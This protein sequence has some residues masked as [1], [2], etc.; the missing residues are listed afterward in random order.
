MAGG[1]PWGLIRFV[2]WPL[3]RAIPTWPETE[4]VLLTP[5]S[6]AFLLNTLACMLWLVWGAFVVDVTR[7][8]V[9]EVRVSSR[10]AMPRTGPLNALAALLVGAVIMA[11]L[12][13]RL[14]GGAMPTEARSIATPQ[15]TRPV[16]FAEFANRQTQDQRR[17]AGT[18]EV[19]LPHDGIYDSLWRVADR[20]L[21]EGSRWPEIFALNRGLTQP[22]G[23]AL[24][25]PDLIRPGWILRLPERP[26]PPGTHQPVPPTPQ[27]P[28]SP[29]SSPPSPAGPPTPSGVPTE[30]PSP[31]SGPHG[32]PGVALP[33]GA[34]VGAGLA[35]LITA[36]LLIVRRRRRIRYEAG[37][38]ERDDLVIAP[39]VRALRLAQEE[40]TGTDGVA[41]PDGVD[42]STRS[43]AGLV[44]GAQAPV[45]NPSEAERSSASG[46]T[47]IIGVKD[48]QELAWNIART[49]GLGLVGSG[50]PDAVRALLVALLAE[51]HQS[52]RRTVEVVVP[53][54]DARVLIGEH[55]S[56]PV[57]LRIVE[58]LDAA[59]DMLE[60]ELLVRMNTASDLPTQD[61]VLIA[62]PAPH[63][64]RRLQAVLDNGS[65]LG[66]AGVLIGQW[67]PGG[68][69]W[70]RADGTIAAT[71]SSLAELNTGVRLFNLPATDARALLDLL[72]DAQ[73]SRPPTQ[74]P[75]DLPGGA[76]GDRVLD[77]KA[78]ALR[79]ARARPRRK[80]A[81]GQVP[82]QEPPLGPSA[83]SPQD[84]ADPDGAGR[85]EEGSATRDVEDGTSTQSAD[86]ESHDFPLA[87]PED[88][89]R[90]STNLG[91]TAAV[92]GDRGAADGLVLQRPLQLGVLGR[93]RLTHHRMDGGEHADLGPVLAPKQREVLAYLALHRGG[94]RRATLTMAIWPDAPRD[95]PYNSFH[96][97]VSQLRRALRTATHD[98]LTDV[99]VHAESYYGLDHDQVE[100][101][102]WH[103]Q[104]V[105]DISRRDAGEQHHRAA[106][107]RAVEL[108]T[109]DF[110]ADLTTGWIEAPREALRREVLDALSALV[111]ITRHDE[112]EYAL[113]LLER[114]RTLDRYNEA[115]YRD[116]A[117]L[118]AHL[119]Q[120]DAIPRTLTLLSTTLAEIDEE[121]SLETV[122]LCDVLQRP[123]PTRRTTGGRAG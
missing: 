29:G 8:I 49:R 97:T 59:L 64:D 112:P 13:Q 108:Y 116:I 80:L 69:A 47:R 94:V 74:Q 60:A 32:Q 123:Q 33:T 72:H 70:I 109:G 61:L 27:P 63:A 89:P 37:S 54:P 56:H 106:L 55:T 85:N 16:A 4:V 113:A 121:P 87:V 19:E 35:A 34:Y 73:P 101:D 10:P 66:L 15:H 41:L 83:R 100:V 75:I 91:P 45:E 31:S 21:G 50:A 36:A 88:P 62:T 110:A 3:P 7:V 20:A 25:N 84:R 17:T 71:S 86:E 53:A 5:M 1:I 111:R 98:R 6:T 65:A 24:T 23:R 44:E 30:S 39:V 102:L 68:T 119:G 115:I 117:R 11:L 48:G 120:F 104:D 105:L 57:A 79:A 77:T 81:H 107:E 26:A 58:D 40:V 76:P 114:G 18:V 93:V 51:V 12:T 46:P 14:A 2:G 52:S 99:T 22:D 9:D 118:Q 95:R 92:E 96:A 42:A 78:P 43:H 122:E 38:G 82:R 90:T 103:L 67:L 28:Q